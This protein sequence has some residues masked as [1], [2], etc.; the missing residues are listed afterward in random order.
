MTPTLSARCGSGRLWLRVL[1]MFAALAALASC[2]GDPA[3]GPSTGTPRAS[4]LSVA[5]TNGSGA[6]TFMVSRDAPLTVTATLANGNGQPIV[7]SLVQLALN[8]AESGTPAVLTTSSGVTDSNGRFS[9]TLLASSTSA[10]GGGTLTATAPNVTEAPSTVASFQVV[11]TTPQPVGAALALAL[12]DPLT[13]AARSTLNR[14][15]PL[16]ATSTL[17]DGSGKPIPN[18]LVQYTLSF[19][20]GTSVAV[21]SPPSGSGVTDSFG[22]FQ[23]QLIASSNTAAGTGTLTATAVGTPS[24]SPTLS[25]FQVNAVTPPAAAPV[26]SL[27][28]TDPVTGAAR[29]SLTLAAPLNATA[30]VLDAFGVPVANS[31]IQFSLATSGG[32]A[33]VAVFLPA[34]G[35]GITNAS[36]KFTIGLQAAG[37]TTQ[38]AGT[39]T[40]RAVNEL[41]APSATSSFQVGA[42][43][44]TIGNV[45]R[46]PP[47]IEPLGTSTITA[48]ISGVPTS[49][50]VTVSFNSSC[51]VSGL[52]TLPVSVV[53]VS[54]V[55]TAVYTDKGC[56]GTD[57][58]TISADGATPVQT[59]INILPA[60]PVAIQFVSA[61][62]ETISVA[63][64]GGQPSS[65]VI[66]K[67]VNAAQ[68]PVANLAV[69][70]SLSTSVG[71]VTLDGQP[72]SIVKQTAADG[73]VRVSVIAGTQPGPV[74]VL[75]TAAG[76]LSAS[77]SQ[78]TIQTGLATQNRMSLSVETLNIEGWN[79]DGTSTSVTLRA[80]DR[81]GNPVPDGTTINFR[82][83]GASIEPSCRTVGG[84]CSVKFRSQANRP[85]SGRVAVLAW[86]VGEETFTDL[87]GNNRYDAG[88]PWGD[89][90]DTFVDANLNGVFDSGEEFIAF[91]PSATSACASNSL[92]AP[93]RPG[94]CDGVWGLAHVRDDG[95]IVLSGSNAF[96]L[97]LPFSIRLTG[98]AEVCEGG[99]SF[100]LRDVN[101]NPMPAG[102]T[103]SASINGGTATVFG[104]PVAN[105]LSATSVGVEVSVPAEPVPGTDPVEKRCQ[106][107]GA[108]TL[109]ISV[110]TPLGTTTIL[111]AVTVT[112]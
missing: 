20:G 98:P 47:Q 7:N 99:F 28:L 9:T 63:G 18:T 86:T 29:N 24:V 84:A 40:A 79:I 78:L 8:F 66:F 111:P 49:V 38:G 109:R 55:A 25:A 53:T 22:R 95:Q 27:A 41:N 31:L 96:A 91:N 106:G 34:S 103:I 107:Q 13:G 69:T 1:G 74:R 97:N 6:P 52:A 101:G 10:Q 68:Q 39:L 42:T 17:V 5:M 15:S 50:P 81:V 26:L 76:G 30:T 48:T 12:T 87:N 54:G 36:G 3:P 72:G 32:G 2:G 16:L 14:N 19:L 67:A 77:S 88:E 100:A 108:K 90:G 112:Y 43:N 51:A 83:A 89:L 4:T 21:L 58:V 45:T 57:T 85:S 23:V 35:T 37:L 80:A 102:T 104:S 44:L 62:P 46:T 64:T 65:V 110:T 33:P 94:S 60:P 75:A 61:T 92:S 71:G 73:T 70:M 59:S 105:T 11:A 93:G 82:S 56:S